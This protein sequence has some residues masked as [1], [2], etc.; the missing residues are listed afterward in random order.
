[1]T[2]ISFSRIISIVA[3]SLNKNQ[4][5]IPYFF[6]EIRGKIN[7]KKRLHHQHSLF[8]RI[9]SIVATSARLRQGEVKQRT[10]AYLT[11]DEGVAETSTKHQP[12][13]VQLGVLLRRAT[14]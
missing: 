5:L 2:I 10:E 3:T 1:M 8:S 11:Y 6:D 14:T 9:V 12:A 13:I 7:Y 4:T